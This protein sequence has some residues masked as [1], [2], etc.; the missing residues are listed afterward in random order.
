MMTFSLFLKNFPGT[1]FSPG[2]VDW[3][4]LQKLVYPVGCDSLKYINE[5]LVKI[6]EG[7][8]VDRG[9]PSVSIPNFTPQSSVLKSHF[10]T[11][12]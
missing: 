12:G 7:M 9:L 3:T 4:A 1:V 5:M 2:V 6:C 10:F 11:A 8:F